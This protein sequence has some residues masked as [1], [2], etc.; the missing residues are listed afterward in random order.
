MLPRFHGGWGVVGSVGIKVK[1]SLG[2][3]TVR[4]LRYIS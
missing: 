4:E 2:L 3:P 1:G